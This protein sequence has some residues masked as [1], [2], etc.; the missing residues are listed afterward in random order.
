MSELN[1][2]SI[3]KVLDAAT[4]RF[5]ET[6]LNTNGT[7]NLTERAVP[8]PRDHRGRVT[9]D[10]ENFDAGQTLRKLQESG[11]DTSRFGALTE[12]G[13]GQLSTANFPDLLRMGVNFDAFTVYNEIPVTYPQWCRVV[14]SNKQQE[15]YVKDAA[16]GLLPIVQEGQPYPELA[17][18]L[19]DGVLIK[20]YKRG[21]IYVVTEEM[22]KF[23]QLGK[24][25]ELGELAGRAGRLTEEQ[26]AM[27][28]LTTTGNY[29]RNSTTGDNDQGANTQTLTFT[30]ANLV[31]AYNVLATM[32]D[33]KTG[34]KLGVNPNILIVAP[35]LKYHAIQLLQSRVLVR[36]GAQAANEVYGVGQ[37]NPFFGMVDTIISSP[38]FGANFEWALLERVR[39]ITFQ[40][41]EPFQLLREAQDGTSKEYFERDV[42]RLRARNWFGVGMRDDRFAFYS[43]STTAPAGS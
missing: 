37:E 20:N 13:G 3:I 21:G 35:K 22:Q 11:Y 5:Q 30:A 40:R 12:A 14:D 16:A 39:A 27:N 28:V 2:T 7:N 31:T 34:V 38:Y 23:D 43:D 19:N 29:T 1:T 42:I 10:A 9:V 15:E 24:V 6:V 26:A 41:V 32:K 18:D 25:R 8:Y 4:G 36:T 17:S 33:R